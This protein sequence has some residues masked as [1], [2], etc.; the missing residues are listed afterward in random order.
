MRI[1]NTSPRSEMALLCR[2]PTQ[3]EIAEVEIVHG[4]DGEDAWTTFGES[5]NMKSSDASERIADIDGEETSLNDVP[6]SDANEDLPDISDLDGDDDVVV[7]KSILLAVFYK[8]FM[9][10]KFPA[11]TLAIVSFW[12][13]E[14][15][16]RRP[17][18]RNVLASRRA[19]RRLLR[20]EPKIRSFNFIRQILPDPK[21]MAFWVR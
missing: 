16:P 6:A 1:I 19:S 20:E 3:D 7:R 15:R 17:G 18:C 9:F 21:N 11:I 8:I 14:G 5:S 2:Q 4:K 10:E 12:R 13:R